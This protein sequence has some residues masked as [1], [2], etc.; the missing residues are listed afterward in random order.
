MDELGTDPL[1]GL[2]DRGGHEG[3]IFFSVWVN[4][5]YKVALGEGLKQI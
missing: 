5:E 1:L 2:A 4:P 3:P